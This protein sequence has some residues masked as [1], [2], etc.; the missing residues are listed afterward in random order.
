M[1]AREL[2]D[3]LLHNGKKDIPEVDVPILLGALE[4]PDL[5]TIHEVTGV[6]GREAIKLLVKFRELRTGFRA[7]DV[8][9]TVDARALMRETLTILAEYGMT[10]ICRSALTSLTPSLSKED[11]EKK[12]DRLREFLQTF[13]KLGGQQ[14]QDILKLLGEARFAKAEA[15]RP[16]MIIVSNSEQKD[17]LLK[18]FGSHIRVEVADPQT[19]IRELI[20]K[21]PYVLSAGP[22]K[23]E[24][25][26]ITIS[27]SFDAVEVC[28]SVIIEYFVRR[29][30]LLQ[31]FVSVSRILADL[32]NFSNMFE[33]AGSARNVLKI[34][35]ELRETPVS[36]ED[37]I[38]EAEEKVNEEVKRLRTRGGGMEDLKI[39]IEDL[40][41]QSSDRLNLDDDEVKLLREAAYETPALPFTFS[42]PKIRA[43]SGSYKKRRAQERYVKLK[44]AASKLE[45][46]RVK[47]DSAVRRLFELDLL[48]GI[49]RFARDYDLSIPELN[50]GRGIGFEHGRNLFLTQD[51]LKGAGKVEPVS[52][53]VGD[54]KIELFGAET[55]ATVMLTGANSG[56]KTTLLETL[57]LIHILTLL[58]LPV[59]AKK[60]DVPLIPIYLFRRRTVRKVGSLEY[61]IRILRPVMAKRQP[62]MLLMDEFE[63]LTEPG[64]LGRIIASVL[65]NLPK[66]SLTLFVTHLAREILP[67]LK[68]S[69]RVDGIE[70]KGIDGQGNLIVDRQP[71][72]N[73]M[74]TSTPELII[75]K[76]SKKA[77]S[78]RLQKAYQDMIRLLEAGTPPAA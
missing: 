14:M 48:L 67:H 54:T 60:A 45:K 19:K 75:S 46:E 24:G 26:A 1:A 7:R 2:L 65:N 20:A 8:F 47:A 62:K 31:T 36:L 17:R 38:L 34:L 12:F 27:E 77:K 72:F 43:L 22:M 76:L 16:P 78:K 56:G 74:G 29:Q 64:A 32:P 51:R 11:N 6:G 69:V 13:Q 40:I 10:P 71:V 35:D 28:P 9:R 3:A 5:E 50:D 58:A 41:V 57:A 53:S 30:P 33:E 59:P 18:K 23:G 68:T 37:F 55:Q 61:A 42:P 73:H 25:E 70:A 66:G 21:E 39:F 15:Q 52:Y 4:T 44:D 49:L 63:A